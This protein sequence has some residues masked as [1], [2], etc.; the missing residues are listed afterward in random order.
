MIDFYYWTTPNGHKITILLEEL[1]LP[2]KITPINISQ[3]A[4]FD[5]EYLKIS[6]NNKIPAIVDNAPLDGGKPLTVFESGAILIYL[7][8][9]TKKLLAQET[10]QRF[11]TLQW[12][13]WQVGGLGPMAGQN[14]HFAHAANEKIPYAIERYI[15][16]TARLYGV[17][18]KQLEQKEFIAGDYSIADIACYPWIVPFERQSQ[19]LSDFPNLKQ[20]FERMQNRP[21][22]I[23][24]YDIAKTVNP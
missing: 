11:T 10:R 4:Q 22:V 19:K 8:D 20:W 7:A 5:P 9:K 14:H 15:K 13:F 23:R 2:Y 21:A 16:E 12:L 1:E 17:L 6:P 18:N 24:A 3:G